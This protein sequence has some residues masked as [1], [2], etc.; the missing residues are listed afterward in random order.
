MAKVVWLGEDHLHDDERGGPTFT[1]WNGV[2]F[3]KGQEVEVTNE[4]AL[5]KARGNPFFKVIDDVKG[6]GKLVG[7]A[8][9]EAGSAA[10]FT[11]DVAKDAAKTAKDELKHGRN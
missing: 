7:D 6:A 2:K 3:P 5:A 8:V 4:K 11:V 10:K 9:K 1:V